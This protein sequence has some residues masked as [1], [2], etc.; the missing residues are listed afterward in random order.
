HHRVLHSFP[1]RRSSDLG[2]PELAAG[3]RDVDRDLAPVRDEHL[4]E[5]G[6]RGMLPCLRG[7]F[8]SRLLRVMSRPATIFRRVWRGKMTSSTKDRKSTRLNSSHVKIS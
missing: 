1:T 6:H 2:D 5:G 3:A 8:R 4:A 7:G